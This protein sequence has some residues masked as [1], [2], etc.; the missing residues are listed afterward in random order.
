MDVVGASLLAF[1]NSGDE[2]T[3]RQRLESCSS[4]STSSSFS[5]TRWCLRTAHDSSP[6][7]RSQGSF[8][9]FSF[10]SVLRAK[11]CPGLGCLGSDFSLGQH[12]GSQCLRCWWCWCWLC[13]VGSSRSTHWASLSGHSHPHQEHTGGSQWHLPLFLFC[14]LGPWSLHA[15]HLNSCCSVWSQVHI[16]L[17]KLA[18]NEKAKYGLAHWRPR[19]ANNVVPVQRPADGGPR[20][21]YCRRSPK[22]LCWSIPSWLERLTILFYSV[23]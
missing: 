10:L 4:W 2:H 12:A 11:R 13:E 23:L 8:T 22:I 7:P 18:K 19:R 9:W 21:S 16:I 5:H 6:G 14:W 20:S 3:L 17:S 15:P 1:G